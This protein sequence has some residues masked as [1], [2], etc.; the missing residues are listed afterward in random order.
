MSLSIYYEYI[1]QAIPTSSKVDSC[2]IIKES[3]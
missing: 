2:I 1:S 3:G